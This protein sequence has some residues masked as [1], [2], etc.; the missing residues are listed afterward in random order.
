[1]IQV[2]SDIKT[3]IFSI[4]RG[5]FGF[6]LNKISLQYWWYLFSVH[7][8]RHGM[9]SYISWPGSNDPCRW[10]RFVSEAESE[11]EA[12]AGRFSRLKATLRWRAASAR[13]FCSAASQRTA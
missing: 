10:L 8:H 11:A 7:Q 9:A 6:L 1:M 5:V 4:K 12:K 3:Y 2:I 13:E